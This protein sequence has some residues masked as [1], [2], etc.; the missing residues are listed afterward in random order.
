MRRSNLLTIAII[1]FCVSACLSA[2]WQPS[3]PEGGPI[4][5]LEIAPWDAGVAWIA[6][7]GGGV[8]KTTDGG[9]HWQNS[10]SGLS[11]RPPFKSVNALKASLQEAGTV[12]AET[13]DGVYRT[14]DSGSTWHLLSADNRQ[15]AIDQIDG[16]RLYGDLSR[17]TDGGQ[18]WTAY[19]PLPDTF[20]PVDVAIDPHDSQIVYLAYG[21]RGVLRSTDAGAHW[22]TT[23]AVAGDYAVERVHTTDAGVVYAGSSTSLQKSEDQGLT[24]TT[25]PGLDGYISSIASGQ[26][27]RVI[28]VICSYRLFA[29]TD[30]GSSWGEVGLPEGATALGV[31]LDAAGERFWLGTNDGVLTSDDGEDTGQFEIK[32]S[33][34]K[35]WPD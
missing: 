33:T 11:G 15:I 14:T 7:L 6:G 28:L 19:G 29:S 30:W 16:T 1:S 12:F 4:G 13:S 2:S 18:S 9:Y 24:W 5:C 32:G 20:S 31:T 23:T 27:G 35:C 34:L 10:G 21:W 25:V 3:G 8:F 22:L 17:S 26:A